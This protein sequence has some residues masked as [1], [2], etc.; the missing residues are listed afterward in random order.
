MPLLVAAV[1]L[2][3]VLVNTLYVA[4][5]FSAV[6]VRRSRLEELAR[7]GSRSARRLLPVLR[8]PAALD[9][10][11]AACQI[12]ITLSSLVLGA[13]GQATIAVPLAPK[14][15]DWT[16]LALPS[17]ESLAVTGVLVVLTALQVILGEL[18]PKSIALQYPTRTAI[19]TAG[20]MR[21]SLWLFRWFIAV[22][23]GSGVLILR[24]LG[25]PA[26]GGHRH[27]HSPEEIELLVAESRDG[28]L[29]E[30]HEQQRLHQAL[31]LSLRSARQLMVPR[32]EVVGVD[33]QWSPAR[34]LDAV[35][36][37][38]YTRLLVFDGSLDRVLGVVH[39]RDVATAFARSRSLEGLRRLI[40]P[41]PAVPESMRAE[42]LLRT[43]RE[44]HSHQALVV[45]EY[46]GLAGLVALQDVV[47]ELL[48]EVRDEFQPAPAGVQTLSDGRVRV[49]GQLPLAEAPAWLARRWS[50]EAQTIAGHVIRALR[51]LP[52]QGERVTVGGVPT[53]IERV[54]GR[55][56][57]SLIVTRVDEEAAGRG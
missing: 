13:Y 20:P 51:R 18:A 12:G 44:Q 48:G 9:R 43:L 26:A 47:S 21:L 30:P 15:A 3:L 46:G 24:W 49:A 8:D 50:S 37:S 40:R 29:L 52:R 16:G 17:A 11:V 27:I 7:R 36:A 42:E 35:I 34:V 31:R 4:A 41:V 55:V 10:Y 54:E 56:P 39:V 45:D 57:A 32:T 28:G 25:M 23:N 14:L 19:L 53:E 2:V 33:L 5:E 6:G 1:I 22:L 38:P